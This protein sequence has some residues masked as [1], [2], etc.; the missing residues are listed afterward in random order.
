MNKLRYYSVCLCLNEIVLEKINKHLSNI[1][2]FEKNE[3]IISPDSKA[4]EMTS[5]SNELYV[6]KYDFTGGL[7]KYLHEQTQDSETFLI[8]GPLVLNFLNLGTGIRY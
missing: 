7:S 8:K 4:N 3:P 6:K 2:K 1:A 5:D